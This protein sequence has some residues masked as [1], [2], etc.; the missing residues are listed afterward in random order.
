MT[1]QE[2]QDAMRLRE[3][4]IA[5][6]SAG[7]AFY[8]AFRPVGYLDHP[9]II[10]NDANG[11]SMNWAAHLCRKATLS[12]TALFES[13]ENRSG[14]GLVIEVPRHG[15]NETDAL[16]GCVRMFEAFDL[17]QEERERVVAQLAAFIRRPEF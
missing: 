9:T 10:G 16:F 15:F 11:Q 14:A 6:T 17:G 8:S 7:M 13:I 1:N 5:E 12:E 4:L 2:I 3:V